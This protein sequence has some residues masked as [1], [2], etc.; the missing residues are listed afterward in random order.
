MMSIELGLVTGGGG[1][2]G[3]IFGGLWPPGGPVFHKGVFFRGGGACCFIFLF[4]GERKGWSMKKDIMHDD[5][6]Y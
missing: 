6:I 4:K 5:I 3:G 1:T 2:G